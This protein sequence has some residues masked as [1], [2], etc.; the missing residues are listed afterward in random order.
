M[1]ETNRIL[2]AGGMGRLGQALARQGCRA[3]GRDRM[4]ITNPTQLASVIEQ[5]APSVIINAAAYTAVDHAEAEPETANRIN[6]TGAGLLARLAAV[7]GIPLI[8]VSTDMVFSEGDPGEPKRESAWTAPTSVYG[9]SK[10]EGETLVRSAGGRHLVTR[11]SWLFSDEGESFIT[12]ILAH[13]AKNAELKLVDDETGR[14][15]HVDALASQLVALAAKL[16]KG[17]SLP[18]VLHLGPPNPVSRFGWAEQVFAAAAKAGG[19]SPALTP[20]PGSAFETPAPR[21][22]G[23][24]L[25]VSAAERLLGPMPD[26]R[27]A[28][29]EVVRLAL[30]A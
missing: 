1:T 16:A 6:A 4:D 7:A 21:P 13:G 22:R 17:E 24:V 11:V 19:P 15:T 5:T 9:A 8:Q 14:P 3:L 23:V 29:D 2:V 18:G 25:D 12:K 26:W 28:S 30:K 20:V 27:A 10:L